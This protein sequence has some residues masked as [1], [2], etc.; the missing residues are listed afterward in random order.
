MDVT[1]DIEN[2]LGIIPSSEAKFSGDS[3]RNHLFTAFNDAGVECEVGEFLYGFVRVLKPD[4]VLETGT[5]QGMSA[6][7]IG[8]ALYLNQK[9]RL[10]TWE[11]IPE[12][13][14]TA[15][16]NINK[17]GVEKFVT[18]F[19]GDVREYTPAHTYQMMLLDTEPQFRFDELVRFF[20]NLEPGG[21]VFIHDLHRHMGQVDNS[22]HG[23]AWPWG[24][25]PKQIKEWVKTD[26]LRP[27][28]FATPRGLTGFYKPNPEDYK[29]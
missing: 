11:F 4:Y 27:F 29:W 7:Y 22:E 13:W 2:V 28:H 14:K 16:E 17:M 26:Q 21:F 20:D 24:K 9:G 10:H 15:T 1:R 23:F 12:H 6:M 5:H 8:N 3:P 18:V 19:N 25:I